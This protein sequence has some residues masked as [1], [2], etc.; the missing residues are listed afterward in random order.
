MGIL[1]TIFEM[2]ISPPTQ[3]LRILFLL[4]W[5]IL[6]VFHRIE[7]QVIG[8]CV[9]EYIIV[10][11]SANRSKKDQPLSGHNFVKWY[12]NFARKTVF[13]K[14]GTENAPRTS[15]LSISPRPVSVFIKFFPSISTRK[16]YSVESGLI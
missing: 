3:H 12:Y 10:L 15:N 14:Y 6:A 1:R 9:G 2:T 7:N 4:R 11:N 13:S 5:K 16:L 8:L